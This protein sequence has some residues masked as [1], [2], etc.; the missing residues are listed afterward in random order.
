MVDDADTPGNG[1]R[2]KVALVTGS[3]QGIGA[4]I[5]RLLA[6]NGATVVTNSRREKNDDDTPTAADTARDIVE[7]GG[8]SVPAYGDVGTV[9]GS[10]AVVDKAVDTFGSVDVLV[11]NAG[12]GTQPGGT[13]LPKAFTD[14]TPEE[15]EQALRTNASSQFFCCQLVIPSMQA[16]G[17]G[18][19][20]NMGSTAGLLGIPQLVAYSGAK[21]AAHSLTLA[22]AKELAD[23]GITVNCVLP[24]AATLR[25]Q[26]NSAGRKRF[27]PFTLAS[28]PLRVPESVAPV[29]AYLCTEEA[30][31]ISGQLLFSGAGRVTLYRWPP[32]AT[33]VVNAEQWT[34]DALD[35]AFARH[36]GKQLGPPPLDL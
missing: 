22:L 34:V 31:A 17:W 23:D 28:E 32:S 14:V 5:A 2:G 21:G 24:S 4:A 33:T 8:T 29:V 18:R 10:R 13:S 6:A 1:L 20:V 35:A 9:D 15:W 26:K 36:L 19:I 12:G 11:N 25:S 7:A 16:S 30:A 3:G 27:S